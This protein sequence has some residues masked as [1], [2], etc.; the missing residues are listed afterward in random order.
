MQA[1]MN[2]AVALSNTAMTDIAGTGAVVA[3]AAPATTE[4]LPSVPLNGA[5][6]PLPVPSAGMPKEIV[7]AI[8]A[9][10]QSQKQFKLD[11]L[12]SEERV[13]EAAAVARQ[14]ETT[15]LDE[16]KTAALQPIGELQTA[17]SADAIAMRKD[18]ETAQLAVSKAKMEV[19]QAADGVLPLGKLPETSGKTLAE[20]VSDA[21]NAM[22]QEAETY[23][24]AAM[25]SSESLRAVK[26]ASL[27]KVK[28][29]AEKFRTQVAAAQEMLKQSEAVAE[30]AQAATK[31]T[32]FKVLSE[33]QTAR[34]SQL[35]QL[36]SQKAQLNREIKRLKNQAAMQNKAKAS[37]EALQAKGVATRM[38]SAQGFLAR[39][40]FAEATEKEQEHVL[41]QQTDATTATMVSK[42]NKQ[43]AREKALLE[44]AKAMAKDASAVQASAFYQ[45]QP[46]DYR[47]ANPQFTPNQA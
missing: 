38:H 32:L 31:E 4:V 15:V 22:R 39:I 11:E 33:K 9:E 42:M 2:A 29:S 19:A 41:N 47:A 24:A 44:Q 10:T 45:Q 43:Q 21:Q 17:M 12:A 37:F 28:E 3:T 23:S 18:M 13:R 27:Q 6:T 25:K 40:R 7:D 36:F 34:Q 16:F 46:A 35:A 8:Q 5:D 1:Q 30:K 26:A 20:E 14:E